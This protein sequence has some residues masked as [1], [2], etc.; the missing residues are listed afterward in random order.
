MANKIQINIKVSAQEKAILDRY[1]QQE[2]RQQ[3]DVIR[4]C[5]R[6]LKRKIKTETEG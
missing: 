4:E 2:D 6:S 3:S 1:C 5:I